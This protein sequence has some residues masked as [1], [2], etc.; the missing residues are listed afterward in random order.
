MVRDAIS[1]HSNLLNRIIN[2]HILDISWISISYCVNSIFS[3]SKEKHWYENSQYPEDK[4][5]RLIRIIDL[6]LSRNI[7]NQI[8]DITEKSVLC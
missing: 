5:E 4:L 3:F 6:F 8:L 2:V 1:N 7:N